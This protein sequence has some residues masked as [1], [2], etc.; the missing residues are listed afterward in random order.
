M[1]VLDRRGFLRLGA[2]AAAS[3]GLAAC[4]V[5]SARPRPPPGRPPS[6]AEWAKLAA[7][8][9]GHL[10][11]PVDPGYPTAVQLYDSRYDGVRPAAVATCAS[12]SDTQRCIAFARQHGLAPIPR[13]GGHSYGGYSTGSGLVIDVGDLAQ[14]QAGGGTATI[15]AGARLIDIYSTLN[16]QGVS[17]P[18]G[19]CP[20]IGMAGLA[21]GG[22]VGVV[23]RRYG[24]TSDAV[25]AV[26]VVTADGVVHR[27][28]PDH[29]PDL[30]WACRGGGGRNFGIA[31]SFE[32]ATFPTDDVTVFSLVWPWT[33]ADQVLPAWLAWAPSGPDQLWSNLLLTTDPSR[34]TPYAIVGGLWQGDASTLQPLLDQLQTAAGGGAYPGNIVYT[35]SFAAAMF[36]EAGCGSL[37]VASCRLPSQ[38]GSLP[39]E[40]I[41]AKSDYLDQP[42]SDAGVQAVLA[43]IDDRRAAGASVT[44]GYDAY[45]GAINRVAPGATAFVHRSA[46][47]SAQ[48]SVGFVPGTPTSQLAA[49]QAWLD[50]WHATLRPYVSGEAYQNYIDPQL[51]G[52]A[53]AYYGDN[54]AR[55]SEIKV[56]V[57][58]D[59]VWRFPQSIPLPRR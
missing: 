37:S 35:L 8:L 34:P 59:D 41:L 42:L 4:G 13:S 12:P 19:S 32:V 55:L 56:A 2:G 21:L 40:P 17:I 23:G 33:A 10:I 38:G 15:G 46:L 36:Y 44:V 5:R 25:Q 6:P 43:G 50:S 57:D 18:A 30:Y 48:Y 45:G 20:T 22:G 39:R 9:D 27:C 7:A 47:A 54:L 31:T 16:G 14:V 24:L 26:T 51:G 49:M 29:D 3:L 1:A 28:D 53:A 52:W 11:L 58:P